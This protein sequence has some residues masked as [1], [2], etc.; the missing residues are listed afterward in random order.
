MSIMALREIDVFYPI[1][2]MEKW[3]LIDEMPKELLE[4]TW[5]CRAPYNDNPCKRCFTC[6]AVEN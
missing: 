4:L 6:Q 1:C 2:E 3:Q 5:W